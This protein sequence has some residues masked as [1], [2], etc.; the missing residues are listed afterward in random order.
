VILVA[1]VFLVTRSDTV[2]E[3]WDTTTVDIYG[4]AVLGAT[5]IFGLGFFAWGAL[6]I[7]V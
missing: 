4:R 6:E 3:A 2:R 5:G 7:L 1:A